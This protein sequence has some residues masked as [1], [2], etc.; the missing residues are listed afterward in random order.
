MTTDT[1]A[2][3]REIRYSAADR[4]F[5]LLLDGQIVGW[6]RSYSEG[7]AILDG[8]VYK[9]LQAEAA[10]V[11]EVEPALNALGEPM[12]A[13]ADEA[14]AR[15]L[16]AELNEMEAMGTVGQ[17][18]ARYDAKSAQVRALGFEIGPD[19]RGGLVLLPA[20]VT[21]AKMGWGS[22]PDA[23]ALV[24]EAAQLG[25]RLDDE[26]RRV[27]ARRELATGMGQW[28]AV[29]ACQVRLAR[30]DDACERAMRRLFRREDRRDALSDAE[31]RAEAHHE[32]LAERA[33]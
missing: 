10:R 25:R 7:E 15:Q 33:A 21:A 3:A 31:E 27:S 4:D 17:Q 2:P 24:V 22:A 1:T 6:A 30:L 19:G 5:A 8:I 32:R 28:V 20:P 9:R 18:I 14:L 13:S 26:R 11:E 29:T 16:V 23:A 12:P